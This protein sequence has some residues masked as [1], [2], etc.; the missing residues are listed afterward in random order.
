M[1]KTLSVMLACVMLVGCVFAFASCGGKK[2]SGTYERDGYVTDVTF[3]FKGSNVKISKEGLGKDSSIEGKYEIIEKEDGKLYISFTF[4]E[5][6]E[7][8]DE[9]KGELSFSEVVENGVEYIK[10][11]GFKYKKTK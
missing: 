9:F 5:D 7:G 3:E 10:V 6:E 11:A 4:A 2:L 8:A 1:K